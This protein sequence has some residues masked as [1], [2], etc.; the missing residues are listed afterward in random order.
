MTKLQ[1]LA[2]LGQAIWL[3]YIRRSHTRSGALKALVD[4][5]VRGMTSNPAIFEQAIAHS[6]DYDSAIQTLAAEGKS[7]EEIY[8]ALALED[9]AEA[10]DVLREVYD[11]TDGLDGY[12]SLEVSPNLAHDTTGTIAEARRLYATLDR[13]NILIKVPA[14]PAGMPAI[15]TLISEGINVNVTLIFS[16]SQYEHVTEAV[17]GGLEKRLASGGDISKVA[18][19]ASFFVSRVDSDVDAKL[20]EIGHSELKGKIAI[21]NAKLAYARFLEIFSGERWKKLAAAGAR[22]QRPLW[23]ST[24]TKN[25]DYP[26]TMYVD[27]L[28]GP[29]TVNTAPPQTLDA[30]LDHGVVAST[31]S[32]DLDQAH[33]DIA[34]LAELGIDLEAVT[35]NLLVVGVEKFVKPFDSL[36]NTIAQKREALEAQT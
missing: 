14:T 35:Q 32:N 7:A 33:A 15:E 8:E 17:I 21:A 26:D 4:Q 28:I 2:Q 31:V 11:Y 30:F 27:T 36:I 24:G 6:D 1:E 19:V 13:P 12:V 20:D 18:S 9:I 10:A 3:D 34:K 5:G 16:V 25:P 22:V 29:N 23:A